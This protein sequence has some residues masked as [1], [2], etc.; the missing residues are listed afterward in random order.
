LFVVVWVFFWCFFVSFGLVVFWLINWAG[1][2]GYLQRGAMPCNMLVNP[3]A[4]IYLC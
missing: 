4:S 2:W 3:A 1:S